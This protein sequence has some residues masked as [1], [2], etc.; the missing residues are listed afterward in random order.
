MTR[1]APLLDPYTRVMRRFSLAAKLQS[2]KAVL[3]WDGQVNLPKGGVWARSEQMAALTEVMID[4]IG[5]QSSNDELCEAEA[6]AATLEPDEQADLREMRNKWAHVSAVPRELQ[7]EKARLTQSLQSLWVQ[8]K[9]DNDFESFAAPFTELLGV[10]QEIATSKADVFQMTPYDALADEFDPGVGQ[11]MIDPIFDDLA[12]FLPSVIAEVRERQ[13]FWPT[14]II[15]G[16][17]PVERQVLLTHRLS[18]AMGLGAEHVRIDQAAHPTSMLHSPGDVRFTTRYDL[19]NVQRGV[20]A[21]LHEAGHSMYE[22]NLPRKWA[23]RSVGLARGIGVHESQSLALEKI[24][25]C[26]RE[27]LTF[28]SPLMTETLGTD[29]GT[30]GFTNVL[31]NWRRLENGF[32]RVEADDLSYPLHVILRY[33]LERALLN[34]DLSVRDLP[35]AWNGLFHQMFGH[36]PPSVAMGCLQDIHWALGLIG[37]FPSYAIGSVLAA[38]LFERAVAD[39]HDI[40]P[41]LGIGDFKPYFEWMKSR[42]HSRASVVDFAAL[43]TDA[44]GNQ[45]GTMAFKR[46]VKRYFLEEAD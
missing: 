14:P 28:L 34:G 35:D 25:G 23:F 13:A 29:P 33:R 39:D 4:L 36:T 41:K 31:R 24:V 15:I 7:I 38:Q 2:A 21:T 42:V 9:A 6:K 26:S 1:T 45:L 43:V 20:M 12:N 19:A 18:K 40:L 3:N 5:S 46:H 44:T 11:A 30:T 22:L 27:F 16:P 17:V 32:I 8:A 10:I 37:Y